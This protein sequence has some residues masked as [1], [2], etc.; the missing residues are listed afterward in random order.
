MGKFTLSGWLL[1]DE[2]SD[3][4]KAAYIQSVK[5][6]DATG[7]AST[8]LAGVAQGS[9]T[10][11]Q[12]GVL[13][14]G[15]VTTAAPTYTTA[16]TSPLSLTTG[17]D[18]R[19]VTHGVDATN[20]APTVSPLY[21]S[22]LTSSSVPSY[23]TGRVAPPTLT[24]AGELI[25]ASGG[26]G[27][28]LSDGQGLG[29]NLLTARDGTARIGGASVWLFNGTGYDKQKK[30]NATGRL[31]SS[32]ATTNA[33]VVKSSAGDLFKIIGNNTVASKR[34]LKLYSKGT[35][36]T[37]GTDTPVITICLLA[38]AAFDFSFT[39]GMYFANGISYAI[40][41]AAADADTTAI[42]AGDIECLNFGYA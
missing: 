17:G 32:A 30:P 34:Y 5:V 23:T 35:A 13:S 31:L 21:I 2:V 6:V 14:Q 19:T 4:G 3:G 26:V 1:G 27:T 18:L 39:A 10:S 40:T 25:T 37:V 22:C 11:G 38:S 36:P 28:N 24:L 15:A 20:A 16:Q 29:I 42:G 41:G 9:T 8:F 7:T 12:S 33:T